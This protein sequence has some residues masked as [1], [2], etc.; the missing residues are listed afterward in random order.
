VPRQEAQGEE[1]LFFK[2][3]GMESTEQLQI[4]VVEDQKSVFASICNHVARASGADGFRIDHVSSAVEATE[5]CGRRYHLLILD[6]RSASTKDGWPKC[7][8]L[9]EGPCML[10]LLSGRCT[11]RMIQPTGRNPGQFVIHARPDGSAI[12]T[13]TRYTL[14]L[15]R[16]GRCQGTELKGR[17]I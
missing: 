5:L 12:E 14:R 3:A 6:T 16:A 13:A 7:E 10:L 8:T 2:G 1:F 11:D 17:V 15:I 4:L 9:L